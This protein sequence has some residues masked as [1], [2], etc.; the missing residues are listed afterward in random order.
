ML[1]NGALAAQKVETLPGREAWYW[2]AANETTRIGFDDTDT[3]G[4]ATC[5]HKARNFVSLPGGQS[6]HAV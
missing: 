3:R 5:P 6:G 1:F 2:N 4:I